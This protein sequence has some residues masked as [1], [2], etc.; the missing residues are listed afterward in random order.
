MIYFDRSDLGKE[1][2]KDMED[3]KKKFLADLK[4]RKREE[5]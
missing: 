4:V 3:M 1:E 5:S 2:L